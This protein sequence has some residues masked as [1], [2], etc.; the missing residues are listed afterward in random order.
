MPLTEAEKDV[1]IKIFRVGKQAKISDGIELIKFYL[2]YLPNHISGA[3]LKEADNQARLTW[4]K[5][6]KEDGTIS[7]YDEFSKLIG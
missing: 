1:L 7:S 2:R 4:Y 3:A 5:W 6:L